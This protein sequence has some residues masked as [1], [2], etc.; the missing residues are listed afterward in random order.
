MIIQKADISDASKILSL[1]KLAYQS[2][3]K[4]YNDFT[5]PP[6]IQTLEE[7]ENKFKDHIFLKAVENGRI[8]GSVRANVVDP[9]TIYI[10]RLIVH[11]D[12]QNQ[13]IGTKLMGKIEACFDDFRRFELMTGHKS[14]KNIYIYRKWGYKI[15]KKEKF[16]DNLYLIYMKKIVPKNELNNFQIVE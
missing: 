9:E 12:Y 7:V 6:L 3:A 11:P 15:F 16:S 13:G 14:K 2:E 5:I 1:Q 10:G 8:I 4:I